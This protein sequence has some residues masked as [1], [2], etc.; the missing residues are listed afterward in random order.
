MIERMT[1]FKTKLVF[2]SSGAQFRKGGAESFVKKVKKMLSH[3]YEG[4]L[5]AYH[6]LEMALKRT[7]SILNFSPISAV[8]CRKGESGVDPDYLQ[9]LNPAAGACKSRCPYQGL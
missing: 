7:A 3:S 1:D 2:C 9:A 6:E 5:I 4:S 8:Y